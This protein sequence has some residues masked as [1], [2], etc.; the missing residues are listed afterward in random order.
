MSKSGSLKC[1]LISLRL[2]LENFPN[3]FHPLRRLSVVDW[4]V[5]FFTIVVFNNCKV[6]RFLIVA[7]YFSPFWSAVILPTFFRPKASIDFEKMTT[8]QQNCFSSAAS[9]KIMIKHP[10]IK[11]FDI[12]GGLGGVAPQKNF[13]L[14]RRGGNFFQNTTVYYGG[15]VGRSTWFWGTT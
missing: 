9:Q 4:D 2:F 14:F 8:I 7:F 10:R 15:G 11:S 3:W 13:E 1:H 6:I 12:G 5:A